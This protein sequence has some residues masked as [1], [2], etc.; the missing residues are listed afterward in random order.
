MKCHICDNELSH[1]EIKWNRDHE[2]WEPCNTCL[3]I[4]AEVFEDRVEY[5]E[6]ELEEEIEEE[7]IYEL[8]L[9]NLDF[10]ENT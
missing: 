7:N 9:D 8:D 2:E 4:I 1:N 5:T 3:H 6:E 10:E